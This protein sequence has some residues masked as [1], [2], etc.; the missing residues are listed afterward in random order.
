[1]QYAQYIAVSICTACVYVMRYDCIEYKSCHQAD[2]PRLTRADTLSGGKK[3]ALDIVIVLG[4]RGGTPSSSSSPAKV[5]TRRK[6]LGSFSGA[7][8]VPDEADEAGG[9]QPANEENEVRRGFSP[10]KPCLPLSIEGT[11]TANT[12][13]PAHSF[14][15]TILREK[16]KVTSATCLLLQC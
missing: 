12:T 7:E 16:P 3:L 10:P 6:V 11:K 8:I 1:M 4:G 15:R 2:Y 13:I 9:H 14:S 5:F